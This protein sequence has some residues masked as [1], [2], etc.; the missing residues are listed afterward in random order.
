MKKEKRLIL[1]KR[2]EALLFIT[3][4]AAIFATAADC[5]NLI[6]FIISKV[7]AVILIT[8]SAILTQYLKED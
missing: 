1:N 5:N 2:G 4:G 3:F 7:I 8:V 6:A